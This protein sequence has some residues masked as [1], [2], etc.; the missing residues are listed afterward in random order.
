[1]IRPQTARVERKRG[2][3]TVGEDCEDVGH[4]TIVRLLDLLEEARLIGRYA[5]EGERAAFQ[6]KVYQLRP[7]KRRIRAV[8]EEPAFERDS[9]MHNA[10]GQSGRGAAERVSR[11][12]CIQPG[13]EHQA[14][15]LPS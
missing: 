14:A 11:R 4:Q 3:V 15:G 13:A 2:A 5:N 9:E 8:A 12:A 10:R 1:M 6:H 7:L